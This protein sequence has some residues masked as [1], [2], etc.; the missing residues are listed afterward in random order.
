MT[1]APDRFEWLA[2]DFWRTIARFPAAV[3]LAAVATVVILLLINGVVDDANDIWPRL[4]LGLGTGAAAAVAG[5]LYVESGPH[6]A[7][8]GIGARYVAPLLLTCIIAFVPENWAVFP[9][10]PV[11]TVMWLSVSASAGLK[12]DGSRLLAQERFWWLNHRAVTTGVVAVAAFALIA[13]G[14]IAIERSLALL[15]GFDASQLFYSIVLPVIGFFFLP[16]YWLSTLPDLASFDPRAFDEPDFLS[17]AIGFLGQFVLTPLLFAYA[18][19]L[20][21]YAAQILVTLTLPQGTLGW[22]VLAFC[23]TG[24]AN[25]LLLFPP[26]MRERPLVRFFRRFWFWLTL[27]PL[28]LFILAVFIRLDA[29]GWTELRALLVLGGIWALVLAAFFLT[30]RGDIRLIPALAGLLLLCA[31]L[32]PW[33]VSALS[34]ADQAH[35]L[36]QALQQAGFTGRDSSPAWTDE[37]AAEA[38]GAAR[39]LAY[40]R[41]EVLNAVL[42]PFDVSL[43]LNRPNRGL[44]A[45]LTN[46]LHLPQEPAVPEAAFTVVRAADAAPLDV[47]ATPLFLGAFSAYGG[48][49]PSQRFFGLAF[50]LDGKALRISP[51]GKGGT[52]AADAVV[53]LSEFVAA[54]APNTPL[55]G[56]VIAFSLG[57]VG[58]RLVIDQAAFVSGQTS[59]GPQLQHLAGWIFSDQPAK[60]SS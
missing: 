44:F 52:D 46:D 59:A 21:A 17:R 16:L 11:S 30:R 5:V 32:G 34:V 58:Y 18:L 4:A 3:G 9:V 60:P 53:D 48:T 12:L 29:Y 39:Y 56:G 37:T 22:M 43:D 33:N 26:F 28:A 24:A 49:P 7:W 57:G 50:R 20:Y 51:N 19:I 41:P 54:Q 14:I 38:A 31:G 27:V 8:L 47:S 10:L 36:K 40:R 55:A 25:W 1:R 13:I 35:R 42:A 2:P 6:A 15:F 23:I 45:L